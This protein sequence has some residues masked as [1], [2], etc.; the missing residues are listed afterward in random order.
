MGGKTAFEKSKHAQALPPYFGGKRKLVP[1]IARVMSEAG[2]GPECGLPLLDG[3][4]GGGATATYYKLLGYETHTNDLARRSNMLATA[5]I[6]NSGRRFTPSDMA[7][8]RQFRPAQP[9]V[10]RTKYTPTHFPAK[11][12]YMIDKLVQFAH[13]QPEPALKALTLL[14]AWKY[15]INLRPMT[16]FNSPNAFNKPFEEGRFDE[17]KSTYDGTLKTALRPPLALLEEIVAT[18]NAGVFANGKRN[19]ATWGDA[20]EFLLSQERGPCVVYL[21]PPYPNTLSYEKNYHPI[22]EIIRNEEFPLEVSDF[23]GKDAWT[24]IDSLLAAA[25]AGGHPFVMVSL[26]SAGGKNKREELMDPI[27]RHFPAS[28]GWR[29]RFENLQY[30]HISANATEDFQAK[31]EEWVYCAWLP[32]A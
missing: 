19:T 5:L 15:L 16:Q 6:Q 11:H 14:I 28:E 3:F 22:D 31:N 25:K 21:D 8:F 9:G 20:I 29:H 32:R 12:G 7:R 27:L 13:A 24:F 4:T 26:G 17:I 18:V 1:F 30:K 23:S 2:Y 10:V